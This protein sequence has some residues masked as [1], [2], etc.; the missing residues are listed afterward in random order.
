MDSKKKIIA[1]DFF[2]VICSEVAPIWFE[3]FFPREKAHKLKNKYLQSVDVGEISLDSLF[4]NLE[5]L[6]D[7]EPAQ[8]WKDWL[9]LAK[10]NNDVVSII[11]SLQK[12]FQVVL[13]SNAVSVFLR[14]ILKENNLE[15]LFDFIII[16]S[17]IGIAKPDPDFFKKALEIIGASPEEIFFI[18]DN[19][20]NTKAAE[21]LGIQTVVFKGIETLKTLEK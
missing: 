20:E 8:I 6:V 10:V 11:K 17:E 3:Q 4:L 12:D 16:S 1:F 2:G 9:S 15:R 21:K 5:E 19:L 13:F 7:V 14:Q 18:D